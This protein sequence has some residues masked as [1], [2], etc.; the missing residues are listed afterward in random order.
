MVFI[1]MVTMVFR[2]KT[3]LWCDQFWSNN[4]PIIKS[5]H[6]LENLGN[7][8]S[9]GSDPMANCGLVNVPEGSNNSKLRCNLDELF[10]YLSYFIWSS[11]CKSLVSIGL[12]DFSVALASRLTM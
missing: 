6:S 4:H 5:V 10:C 3:G 9:S 12:P 2:H 7:F 8:C 1:A 11:M